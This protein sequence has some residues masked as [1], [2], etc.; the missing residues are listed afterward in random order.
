VAA[1]IIRDSHYIAGK[2][3]ALLEPTRKNDQLW[4]RD[5]RNAAWAATNV[6][7]AQTT[8]AD[9]VLNSGTRLTATAGNGTVISA[10]ALV[11][12]AQARGGQLYIKRVTGSGVIQITLDGGATWTTITV[13]GSYA[14]QWAVQTL[15]NSQFGIRIV[16]SG[17]AV[18]VDYTGNEQ[19]TTGS[20]LSAIATTTAAV[21]RASDWLYWPYPFAPN[22]TSVYVDMISLGLEF[23]LSQSPWMIGDV[24]NQNNT[25]RWLLFMNGTSPRA[26]LAM[27]AGGSSSTGD[28][29]NYGDRVELLSAIIAGVKS[30]LT[31][32]VNGGTI[33]PRA[34]G[35]VTTLDAAY[36]GSPNTVISLGGRTDNTVTGPGA[37]SK[38]VV[39]RGVLTIPA[40][41]G[42]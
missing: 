29:F 18:D 17:D 20:P 15:A 7:T 36:A 5:L 33:I 27:T 42:L 1:N 25:P 3:Y 30:Q 31:T 38:F 41:R 8:G 34:A 12:G 24:A 28:A 39:S 26:S 21:T 2:R 11:H 16:T 10:A 14:R 40:L 9:G 13:T 19:T 6:T 37:Y 22:L 23:G 35:L 32:C 4:C